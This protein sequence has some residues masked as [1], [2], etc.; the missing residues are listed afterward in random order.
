MIEG[1]KILSEI[2]IY[3]SLHSMCFGVMGIVAAIIGVVC[4][5]NFILA[6]MNKRLN[7]IYLLMIG[8]MCLYASYLSFLD[9]TSVVEH[10][11][12]K[13]IINDNIN[14]NEFVSQYEII[15]QEGEIY[16]VKEKGDINES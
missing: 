13:V 6:A 9:M 1:V 2:P 5:F 3:D 8:C 12:Y 4:I 10:M 15:H 7:C 11:Q 16:T 14:F